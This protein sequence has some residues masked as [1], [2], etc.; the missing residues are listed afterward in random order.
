MRIVV[1]ALD[2]VADSGLGLVLDVF[3]TANLLSDRIDPSIPPFDTSVRATRAQ[4][5]TGY[6]LTVE[7]ALLEGLLDDPPD[8]LV[9]PGFGVL[10]ADDVIEA[11]TST[12]AV[13]MVR[14]LHDRGVR[15][16]AACSGT[17][18]L[19]EAGLLDARAAT[20]SWWLGPVFRQRY[21]A[22]ALDESEALVVADTVTTAGAALAHLDLA[23]ALVRRVSPQLAEAVSDYLAVGDRPRQSESLR[24]GLLP[25]TDPVLV[26]FDRAVRERL[27]EPLEI[28]V[29]AVE[30]GVSKRTLQRLSSGALGMTPV[31]YVQQIRLE[32]A[33]DLLRSTDLSV[34]AIARA[35]GYQDATTLS[36]LIRRRR[37]TTPEQVR[38]RRVATA[39]TWRGD[40]EGSV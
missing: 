18:L 30:L 36:T 12:D 10:S 2:G 39:S 22:V 13:A 31:R 7:A 20:T 5:R 29:L 27:D 11:V 4:V 1:L 25:I 9:V 14:K 3:T 26:A 33:V 35:V 23:L 34:A 17:F 6:G 32:R 24:A 38:R 21:P 19:A 28:G 15:T 37:G 16:S 40:A 8:H